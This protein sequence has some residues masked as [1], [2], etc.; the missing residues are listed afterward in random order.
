MYIILYLS[1]VWVRMAPSIYQHY[2]IPVN[3]L[4]V[5]KILSKNYTS[6]SHVVSPGLV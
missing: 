4:F 3:F 5:K 1:L 2:V 6:V